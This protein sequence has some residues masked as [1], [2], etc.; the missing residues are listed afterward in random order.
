MFK[1]TQMGRG[2]ADSDPVLCL[3]PL[4]SAVPAPILWG[5]QRVAFFGP[6]VQHPE[7]PRVAQ[8]PD[9]R[10]SVTDHCLINT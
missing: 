9:Q 8:S 1:V 5:Q 10:L 3:L 7:R 2:R 6:D 4:R